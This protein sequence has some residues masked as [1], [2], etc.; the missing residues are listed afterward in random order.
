MHLIT[1]T[2]HRQRQRL[3]RRSLSIN[4]GAKSDSSTLIASP[5]PPTLNISKTS[6][7][8]MTPPRGCRQLIGEGPVAVRTRSEQAI[9]VEVEALDRQKHL[10]ILTVSTYQREANITLTQRQ[11]RRHHLGKKQTPLSLQ[12]LPQGR[13]IEVAIRSIMPQGRN[14]IIH[15]SRHGNTKLAG[16]NRKL[17]VPTTLKV[18][19]FI[20][21]GASWTLTATFST[22]GA[23]MSLVGITTTSTSTT[24]PRLP[25]K[26]QSRSLLD[27]SANT[28]IKRTGMQVLASAKTISIKICCRNQR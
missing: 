14:L 9:I 5:T 19:T 28:M 16:N 10:I 3:G 22:S 2:P 18:S 12:A 23:T 20:R 17:K 1:L 15:T 26:L 27:N 25:K 4:K 6:Q 8:L 7:K 21:M 13:N 11:H 24:R